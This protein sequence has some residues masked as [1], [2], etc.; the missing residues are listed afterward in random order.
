MNAARSFPNRQRKSHASHS[1]RSE[2]STHRRA[3]A[4]NRGGRLFAIALVSDITDRRRREQR[5]LAEL[6]LATTLS[7]AGTLD[8]AVPR[9]LRET[10]KAFEWYCGSFWRVDPEADVLLCVQAWPSSA[11]A[12]AGSELPGTAGL[13]MGL[14][15]RAWS[16]GAPVC[17]PDMALNPEFHR[18]QSAANAGFHAAFAFPVTL[19]SDVVGVFEFFSREVRN[20][21]PELLQLMTTVGY[22]VGQFIERT[23]AEDALRHTREELAQAS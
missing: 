11:F 18:P 7:E 8:E 3:R 12:R 5:L 9:I 13:G 19:R 17:I 6:S 22:Q 10:C 2:T 1:T 14:P 20:A 21:D 15:G 16:S 4:F 23:R